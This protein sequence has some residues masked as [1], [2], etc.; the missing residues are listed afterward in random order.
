MKA[1][2]LSP[3]ISLVNSIAGELVCEGRDFSGNLVVFPGKRPAH[4]LRK[5]LAQR[6]G[7]AHIPPVILSMDEF[8][9]RAFESV[10]V[11]PKIEPLDAVALLFDIHCSMNQ[12]IG[13]KGFSYLDSFFG[14]G[15]KLYRD[16]EELVIEQISAD[17]I[18][19]I[20][21]L[22][23]EAIPELSN[24]RTAS[25]EI[26]HERFYKKIL[27]ESLST[28]SL[29]YQTVADRIEETDIRNF[30][31]IIF[32]GFFALTV[33]EKLIF[34]K[35][36]NWNNVSLYF[37]KGPYIDET[38]SQLGITPDRRE[39]EDEYPSVFF[40]S[41]PDSHGQ[42]FALA[43]IIRPL[44]D[45]GEIDEKI[46]VVLPS[47][48]TLFPLI[49]HGLSDFSD[50]EFNISM[51]YPLARTPLFGFV[52]ALM[53]L[54]AGA[55]NGRIHIAEYLSFVLHP[56]T[57]NIY[58]EGSAEAT[59]IIFHAVE[60]YYARRPSTTFVTLD[61]MESDKKLLNFIMKRLP[62][63]LGH[64][65][66][67]VV[68]NHM[69]MVHGKTLRP[70]FE[71][72][73]IGDFSLKLIGLLSYITEQSTARLHPL[74]TPFCEAFIEALDSIAK[75]LLGVRRFEDRTGY[76]TFFRRYLMTC[77]A[78]FEGTP[79]RGLQALGMLETRNIKFDRVFVLDANED[80]L[81]DTKREDSLIPGRARELLGL[82][83]Y[84]E[85]DKLASYY[86]DIMVKGASEVNIF[87]VE[88]SQKEKSRF[89]EKILWELQQRTGSIDSKRFVRSLQY[90]VGL[91]NR[92]PQHVD[93]SAEV[94][95]FLRGFVYSA[96]A[97]D[98]YL[99]CPL[100]F[101]Y[102]YG[103]KLAEKDGAG[104][105]IERS[106]IGI[107]VH[108]ALADYFKPR[109]GRPLNERDIN[110]E[111]MTGHITRI[112]EESYGGVP[113]GSGYLIMKQTQKRLAEYLEKYLATLVKDKQIMTLEVESDM[114]AP[115]RDFQLKGRLDTA[116]KRDGRLYIIDYK[117]SANK[118]AYK[119]AFDKLDPD[120]RETWSAVGSMQLPV[121][122]IL[123]SHT[124]NIDRAGLNAMFLMLGMTQMSNNIELPLFNEAGGSSTADSALIEEILFRLLQEIADPSVPF[125]PTPDKKKNC[126]IC[127]YTGIC[128]TQ[129]VQR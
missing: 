77:R 12:R 29:R 11:R 57:K 87:F 4:F 126:P 98:T 95:G 90:C 82:S 62:E 9:D 102:R 39:T 122:R 25:L 125:R 56:Y 84:R 103:L 54:I 105:G 5:A 119:I 114:R 66:E 8:V 30:S 70:F 121:Y 117:T 61:E 94:N 60:E 115:F 24:Q 88:N 59:R 108:R 120:R 128:G 42:V 53:E 16:I 85:R 96:S 48:D 64:I 6:A 49:R 89:V 99:A 76:F 17:K 110:S 69:C 40:M 55:D 20:S 31:K 43:D 124:R 72:R 7:G 58:F 46:A 101:Y 3:G 26:F 44:K 118:G 129:W 97:I 36:D 68:N 38:L 75:S 79:L 113:S 18:R 37:Q 14:I 22:A 123:Y 41:S 15:L 35:L 74:F 13:G 81:P 63:D 107:I 52:Q 112:F 10:D 32:A 67:I 21:E 28:R 91:E 100:R 71:I 109:I 116:Q 33:S 2:L 27:A 104:E 86:F 19:G 93:K 80:I 127:D 1:Y 47:A 73:D 50:R 83:T 65:S 23:E 51:G 78:P 111:E 34:K 106:D 92:E 45:K